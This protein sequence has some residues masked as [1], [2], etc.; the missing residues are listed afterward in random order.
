[1]A[2]QNCT[3]QWQALYCYQRY[4]I[5]I[6]SCKIATQ[7][8]R[9]ASRSANN[10]ELCVFPGFKFLDLAVRET[11]LIYGAGA[12]FRKTSLIYRWKGQPLR[13]SGNIDRPGGRK[14]ARRARHEKP[15]RL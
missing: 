7:N 4:K 9:N 8:C 6:Q 11:Y 5:C 2:I 10:F 14:L 1:V 3:A 12:T 13:S 15:P